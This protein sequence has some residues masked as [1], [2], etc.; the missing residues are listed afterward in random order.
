MGFDSIAPP[1]KDH[2]CS[3]KAPPVPVIVHGGQLQVAELA[4]QLVDVALAHPEVQV[5]HQQLSRSR[6][7]E[8]SHSAAAVA[9]PAP[10]VHVVVPLPVGVA[11]LEALVPTCG[12]RSVIAAEGVQW[13]RTTPCAPCGSASA[14]ELSPGST[15]SPP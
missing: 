1:L 11:A 12:A 5:A 4:E 6:C 2:L 13:V 7:G 9:V 14:S 8:S 3:A 15:T 10:A